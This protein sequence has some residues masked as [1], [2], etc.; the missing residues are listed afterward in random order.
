MTKNKEPISVLIASSS[1]KCYDVFSQ[2]MSDGRFSKPVYA[3]SIGEAKRCCLSQSF[4]II[5]V[6]APLKDEYGTEF[7]LDVCKNSA[8]GVVILVNSEH[9]E[10]ISYEANQNGVLTVL[11]PVNGPLLSEVIG[12]MVGTNARLKGYEIKNA[13][14][15]AKMDEIRTVNRAKWI[16][17][18]NLG[19]SEDEAHHNIERQAM[20]K[21]QTKK[22]VCETI[23]KTYDNQ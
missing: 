5:V 8:A 10:Q 1:H 14:L 9:F 22:E 18:K 19:M 4:D 12:L 2:L 16:L 13:K 23:I 21:R 15:A 3:Q 7:A 6:N 20:D 17:I 11:K